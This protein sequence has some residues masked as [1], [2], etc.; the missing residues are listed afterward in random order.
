MDDQPVSTI[1]LTGNNAQSF[2]RSLFMPSPGTI[3]RRREMLQDICDNI[4]IERVYKGYDVVV[5]G[6]EFSGY[7]S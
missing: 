4:T 2:A 1:T 3:D 7:K 6:I 5:N